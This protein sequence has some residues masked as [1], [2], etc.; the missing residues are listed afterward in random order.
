LGKILTVLDLLF[1]HTFKKKKRS[2]VAGR[3][4]AKSESG[5]ICVVPSSSR[6]N[7]ALATFANYG[8][9]SDGYIF[10]HISQN[11]IPSFG[12]LPPD[13]LDN[14]KSA[15]GSRYGS[16]IKL[17]GSIQ[18]MALVGEC[19]VPW[20]KWEIDWE[21]GERDRKADRRLQLIMIH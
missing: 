6:V 1:L 16:N 13:A 14:L 15:S 7:D 20:G 8:D 10:R 2:I 21:K 5:R 18:H 17:D 11:K 19:W 9:I 12:S 4:I 3:R